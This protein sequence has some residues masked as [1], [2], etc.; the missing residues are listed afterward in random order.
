M[1][2]FI[3]RWEIFSGTCSSQMFLYLGHIEYGF[4]TTISIYGIRWYT[5]V[6]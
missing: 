1:E 6:L 2:P 3:D 4:C 5:V